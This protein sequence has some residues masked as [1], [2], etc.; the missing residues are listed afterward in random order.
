MV[1]KAVASHP[2][3]SDMIKAA[4]TAIKDRKGASRQAIVKYIEATHKIPA[5]KSK[6]HL[7]VA[8]KRGIEKKSLVANGA[9]YKLGSATKA[10]PK[11]VT[12]KVVKKAAKK[13]VK[14]SPVAK[15]KA[16]ATKAKP[17]AKKAAVKKAPAAKKAAAKKPA[18][19]KASAKK[20]AVKK[21]ASK[22]ASKSKA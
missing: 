10:A 22:K 14:K 2:Q 17:A 21:A 5:E 8:L 16:A 1:A 19:K 4:I 20:P 13:I 9:R 18:V 6:S 7:K 12:K 3:Y 11:K 15:K